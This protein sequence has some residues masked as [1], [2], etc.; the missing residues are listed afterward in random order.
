MLG[1]FALFCGVIILAGWVFMIRDWVISLRWG[2]VPGTVRGSV[3]ETAKSSE[4]LRPWVQISGYR[5]T[6]RYAYDFEEQT[7]LGNRYSATREPF[8]ESENEANT[9]LQR[10][11]LG[12]RIPVRVNPDDPKQSLLVRELS[13]ADA[14]PGYLGLGC[15]FFGVL[16]L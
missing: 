9:F 6:L 8:F 1:P 2:Q 3:V 10:F 14:L 15:L 5:P 16:M 13:L 11:P 4:P 12:S 7:Y